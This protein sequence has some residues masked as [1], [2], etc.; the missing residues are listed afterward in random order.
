MKSFIV[1]ANVKMTTVN[2]P[3]TASGSTVRTTGR[4]SPSRHTTFIPT[5]TAIPLTIN[6]AV[7]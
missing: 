4:L 7:P 2:N 5:A 3:G 6:T 1:N